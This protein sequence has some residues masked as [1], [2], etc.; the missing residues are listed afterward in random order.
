M[1]PPAFV[2]PKNTYG[3]PPVR[4]SASE[5][6]TSTGTSVSGGTVGTRSQ[7][8]AVPEPESEV[9]EG[10]WAEVLYDYTS[11]VRREN[12]VVEVD[13]VRRFV[14]QD[15]GDLEIETGTRVFVTDKSSEDWSVFS[16]LTV[17]MSD[18]DVCR[19]TGQIE[20]QGRQGL[21]PASYV[22]LL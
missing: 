4:R 20:G 10:E 22:K 12:K 11:E 14:L 1:I 19:W 21:F 8:Q 9:E 18:L 16:F 15:P 5:T 6:N 3:P 2:A 13:V 17:V 7:R